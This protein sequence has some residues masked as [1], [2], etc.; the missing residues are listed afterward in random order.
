MKARGQACARRTQL[1]SIAVGDRD[2]REQEC[3]DVRHQDPDQRHDPE[4]ATLTMG[5][6]PD[7]RWTEAAQVNACRERAAPDLSKERD[8]HAAGVWIDGNE[9]GR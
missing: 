3:P 5:S 8:D 1:S 4:R 7:A 2:E 9:A 6:H